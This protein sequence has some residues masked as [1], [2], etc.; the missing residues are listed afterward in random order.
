MS[1][2]KDHESDGKRDGS[3]LKRKLSRRWRSNSKDEGRAKEYERLKEILYKL[4]YKYLGHGEWKKLAY[5][6]AFTDDQIK[7]IEHQYNGKTLLKLNQS[8]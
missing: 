2:F 4:A 6:W 1:I 7:A 3:S 8:E 5:H